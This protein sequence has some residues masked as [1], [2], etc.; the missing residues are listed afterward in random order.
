M[1][2][3]AL[4]GYAWNE[5]LN[6]GRNSTAQAREALRRIVD[7]APGPQ[8]LAMLVAKIAIRLGEIESVFTEIEQVTRKVSN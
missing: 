5:T 8:T 3:K 4:G 2:A 7:E 6:R 1:T